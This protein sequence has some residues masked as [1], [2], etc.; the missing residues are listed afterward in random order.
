MSAATADEPIGLLAGWGRLPLTIARRARE[1][2]RR[3][4]CIGLRGMAGEE[5]AS[6]VWR[7]HWTAPPRL[8]RIIRL[9]KRAGARRMVMAGKVFKVDLMYRP[10]GIF[11]LLPDWRTIR[12]WYAHRRDNKDDTLQLAF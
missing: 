4:V 1:A 8:G 12:A 7:F 6:E 5:L 3:V 9:F 10:W 2:G 11:G